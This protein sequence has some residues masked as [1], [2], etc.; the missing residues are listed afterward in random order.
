MTTLG[1]ISLFA[2]LITSIITLEMTT[3]AHVVTAINGLPPWLQITVGAVVGGLLFTPANNIGNTFWE[4]T[5]AKARQTMGAPEPGEK[6]YSQLSLDF[7]EYE[8]KLRRESV[9]NVL[10]KLSRNAIGKKSIKATLP[11][12]IFLTC[13]A[14]IGTILNAIET[15]AGPEQICVA[16]IVIA[17]TFIGSYILLVAPFILLWTA[18]MKLYYHGIK[19]K[20]R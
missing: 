8:R 12:P 1:A 13:L 14:I 6:H 17:C 15:K 20:E 3:P 10:L 11:L 4:I 5:T 9:A 19:T 18:T 7:T 16:L 2:W